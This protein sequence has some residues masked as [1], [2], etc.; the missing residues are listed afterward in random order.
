MEDYLDLEALDPICRYFW[1]DG[2]RLDISSN[3]PQ[4]V[5]ALGAFSPRDVTGLFRFLAYARNLFERAG[6]I[7]LLRER[8]HLWDLFSPRAVDV[9]RIDALRSMDRAVRRFFRDP[10]LVQ[11]FD[12]YATYNGS[13]PYQAPATLSLVPYLEIA[14]G[15]WYVR[16]GMYRLAE[17]LMSV[18]QEL[19]VNFQPEC[20]VAEI[21]V[22]ERGG[23]RR[24]SR[25]AGVR[26]QGGGTVMADHVV[27]N[28]DAIY[29][30][31]TLLAEGNQDRRLLRR[32]ERL[33]PSSSG[34]VLLLGVKG[35]YPSLA[36]HN[37]FFSRDYRDEFE[38]IFRRR[39][40]PPEPTIYVANST[41][42]DPTQAPPGHT[43]LFVL[44]NVP[45]LTSEADW[46]AWKKPY[47]DMIISRLEGLGLGNLG[48][49]I[50]FEQVITPQDFKESYNSW[51]GS[52][53]G[54]SSNSRQAAF[55]R[56]PNRVPGVGNL[57]F[58]GGSV[59]PGGGIPLV[60]L[61]ARLVARMI[62]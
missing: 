46:P 17:A 42:N 34:F 57:Y 10:R 6:P 41:R 49:R 27:V 48:E 7:F 53:Y 47:R 18:A 40:P 13:S 9:A 61:S 19:G 58:V 4:L 22:E 11:L 20:E 43:N 37:V 38:Y 31:P 59:H 15:G 26:L 30:Y 24:A 23:L 28:A 3:L 44:V 21:I 2:S 16:G 51:H 56:P 62:R 50:V 12:R 60:L 36:H 39:E 35:E 52:I 1:P 8:P 54:I 5:S 45:A 55:L 32:M 33:E 29:A 25:A 14:G